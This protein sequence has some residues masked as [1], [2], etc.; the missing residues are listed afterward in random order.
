[1]GQKINSNIKE[2]K[3]LTWKV[4]NSTT[5]TKNYVA[6]ITQVSDFKIYC[7]EKHYCVM[8]I[9]SNVLTIVFIALVYLFIFL[10]ITVNNKTEIM[11]ISFSLKKIIDWYSNKAPLP[12]FTVLIASQGLED[13]VIFLLLKST[14]P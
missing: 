9:V 6:I 7:V 13:S 12:L 4:K 1:M 11:V 8:R 3:I 5:T 14:S 10:P 2:D